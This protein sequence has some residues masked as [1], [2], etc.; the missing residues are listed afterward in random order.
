MCVYVRDFTCV[1]VYFCV[2]Y[3]SLPDSESVPV[4]VSVSVST[5]LSVRGVVLKAPVAVVRGVH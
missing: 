2:M 4:S 1:C 5:S 3:V